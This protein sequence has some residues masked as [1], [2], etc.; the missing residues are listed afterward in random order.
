MT[1]LL[2]HKKIVNQKSIV[3]GQ[4]KGSVTGFEIINRGNKI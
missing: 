4:S 1:L 2:R 3:E